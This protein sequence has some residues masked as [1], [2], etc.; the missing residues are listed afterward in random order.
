MTRVLSCID[1][2]PLPE[3]QC[4]Q[5]A[6][7][8]QGGIADMLPTMAEANVVGSAFFASLVVIAF[9]KRTIKPPPR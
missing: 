5:T 8:E 1:P 6:W 9:V 4:L 7:I 3:G 2:S